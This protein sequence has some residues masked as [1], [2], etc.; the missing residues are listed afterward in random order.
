MKDPEQG[1]IPMERIQLLLVCLALLLCLCACG[2]NV[3]NVH[4][5]QM[6]SELYSE[7]DIHDAIRVII[8]EFD[9]NWT[10]CTLLSISYAGDE[11]TLSE[12]EYYLNERGLY[13]ADEMIV[14]VSAFDV[15]SSGGDGSLNPNSTY[16]GWNWL[17]VR[18]NGGRW[19]HV[20]H[21]YG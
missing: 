19:K 14:L 4:I 9:Q 8:R 15:D 11:K 18:N 20:D 10:G 21:G 13:D 5:E 3:K 2:G 1:G 6:G 12:S 7:K 16:D 17:L